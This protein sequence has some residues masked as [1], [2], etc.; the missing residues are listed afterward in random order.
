ML[1]KFIILVAIQS[2]SFCMLNLVEKKGKE[3]Q[4]KELKEVKKGKEGQLKDLNGVKKSSG[5]ISII[6][7]PIRDYHFSQY[8]SSINNTKVKQR[9]NLYEQQQY[10]GHVKTI[11]EK[12]PNNPEN[13]I[14]DRSICSKLCKYFTRCFKGEKII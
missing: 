14:K 7:G 9:K 10:Y 8:F 13:Q 6:N 1:K 2:A 4:L 11:N 5:S 12:H 3:G